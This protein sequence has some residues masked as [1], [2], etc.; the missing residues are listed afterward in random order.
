MLGVSKLLCG[1]KTES[2]G[3]RYDDPSN[4]VP[5]IKHERGH[6]NRPVV[7]W[8]VTLQCNLSCK[9]CYASA[10]YS[11]HPEELSTGKA[12]ELI[13]DLHEFGV[14]V[15]IF[16]GGEPLMRDDL[17]ELISY[18]N[19][20]GMR[21]VLSTNGTLLTRENAIKLMDVY[22][23]YVG[24]SIDG[25][26]DVN[27]EFRGQ[28]GAFQ[29][30]LQGIRNCINVGL[31]TGLRYTI[32]QCNAG[33]MEDLINLLKREG[34]NRYCFYHLDYG[35][36]GEEIKRH[37]LTR[38]ETR[39]KIQALF[40]LTR[41]LHKQ[42]KAIEVL[43][44]G[45]YADAPFLYLYAREE[46]GEKQSD[47]IYGLLRR[48]GGDGTGETIADI[49]FKGDVHPNQ[50]WMDYSFG[51]I[52]E[53]PFSEIWI[54]TSDPLMKGLKNKEN[55]LKGKCAEC[56]FLEICKGGS[57]VRALKLTGDLWAPDPKCY[58]KKEEIMDK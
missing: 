45:N 42:G 30:A 43:T 55:Y 27:D 4:A 53:R 18:A 10:R 20:R 33:E 7:V 56:R 41:S 3:L 17:F 52:R 26:E 35:G 36:L 9:H 57:R 28:K 46:L 34:V 37:D 11:T 38:E 6:R 2:D 40:N 14:P 54:D 13:D 39:E 12:K 1:M 49:D 29:R 19:E 48:N 23:D 15:L 31:K 21:T 25:L 16:S 47:H 22:L 24:V 32:T 5:Q 51:N 8:N 44:V 58:L 50:F